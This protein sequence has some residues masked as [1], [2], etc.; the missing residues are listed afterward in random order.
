MRFL[1]EVTHHPGFIARTVIPASWTR[2]QDP[3]E[4]LTEPE[5]AARRA[6]DPRSKRVSERWR[7][8]PD[9]R[10]LWKGDTS[11]DEL[12]AHLF[13]ALQYATLVADASERG[14]VRDFVCAI[15]DHL[16]AHDYQLVDLDGQPTRWGVWSPQRLWHDPDWANEAGINAVELLSYLKLAHHLSGEGRYA[17]SYHELLERH[18]YREL[19][20]RAK[21]LNPAGRTHIDDELLA[22]AWP[23]LITLE[24][25]PDLR[26]LYREALER[27]HAAVQADLNPFFEMLYAGLTGLP[28][29]VPEAVA[30]LR[31]QPLD[32]IRW[33]VDNSAR[34][35]LRAVRTPEL[36]QLQTDRLLPPDERGT[37]RTDENPRRLVQGDGGSTESDGV[38]WLLPYWMGRHYGLIAPPR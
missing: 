3:N 11:S 26:A 28:A 7:P 27:W 12:T 20:L 24:T 33:T 37:P 15:V 36:E 19:V 4:T 18:R 1:L 29:A 9:G 2:M 34:E 17:Q 35:D 8:S 21:N 10:W 23:A 13:G 22:F 31:A 6:E 5:W 30:A 25:Q 32:L 38:F 16:L 14:R